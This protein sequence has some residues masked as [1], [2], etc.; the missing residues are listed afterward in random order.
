MALEISLNFTDVTRKTFNFTRV[1]QLKEFAAKESEYWKGKWSI[2][3]G[4]G[5][6]RSQSQYIAVYSIWQSVYDL[7]E[8][9]KSNFEK[10]DQN[11]TISQLSGQWQN[12]QNQLNGRWIWSGHPVNEA[13]IESYRLSQETGEAFINAIISNS[14]NGVGSFNVLK[15]MILA[16]EFALQDESSLTKRRYAEEKSFSRLR[17]QLA[18]KKDELMASVGSFQEEMTT[19]KNATQKGFSD[20][21]QEKSDEFSKWHN[22]LDEAMNKAESDRISHFTDT[23][24]TWKS[25]VARLEHTYHEKL[26]LAAPASY[27]HRRARNLS[28]QGGFWAVLLVLSSIIL[29]AGAGA[30]FWSWLHKE[31]IPFGP[32]SLQGV[33]LFGATAAAAVFLI[34]TL[35]KLTFSAFHLQRDAEEKEQLTHLYLSLVNEGAIDAT[36]R[37]I[38][39]QALFSRA[40]TGLLTGD[41]GPTMP[42]MDSLASLARTAGPR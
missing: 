13:W 39:L 37:D 41:S 14:V 38:V 33:V 23:L 5:G 34:R 30:F 32:Q 27:W 16:Y 24:D 6:G 29:T 15:G 2:V 21:H 35:S 19:W 26:R 22:G 10:W 36:S 28:F 25:D 17:T 1:D 4:M 9:W 40:E 31:P 8:G 12:W 11:T 7:L 42:G 20:W 18:D 3:S